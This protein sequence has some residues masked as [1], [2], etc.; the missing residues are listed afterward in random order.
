M[1]PSLIRGNDNGMVV[2]PA[3]REN[4][5]VEEVVQASNYLL[6]NPQYNSH[7]H[8][9]VSGDLGTYFRRR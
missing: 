4:R 3:F 5:T 8:I 6:N 2:N 1:I 7:L 9:F